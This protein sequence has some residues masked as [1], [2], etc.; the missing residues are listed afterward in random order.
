MDK[1]LYGSEEKYDFGFFFGGGENYP[2][3]D[4]LIHFTAHIVLYLIVI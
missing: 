1:W 3:N 2:F 4:K